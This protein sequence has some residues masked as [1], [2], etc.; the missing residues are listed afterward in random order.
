MARSL[1]V[2]RAVGLSVGR[3]RAARRGGRPE[4]ARS[5]RRRTSP[6]RLVLEA[7]TEPFVIL[8]I[9][10]GVL[11]IALGEMRDGL[12]VLLALIPIV[13]ADVVTDT[14]ANGRSRR[15]ARHR[16]RPRASGATARPSRPQRPGWCPGDIV[17][18]RAGD[19][20][21][22]DLRILR[23]DRLLIDRSVLTGESVPEPAVA[24]PDPPD[25]PLVARRVDGLRRH[26]RRRRARRGRRRRHRRRAPRSGGSRRGSGSSSAAGRR[27]RRE[28]D[29]LVRILLVVAH[30]ADR[31]RDRARVRSRP[32]GRG[33]PAGRHLGRDRGDPR[34][35]AG[36]ARGDPRPGRVP[37]AA[38]RRPRPAAQR[39]G[40]ARLG[41]PDHH[42]QDRDADPQPARRRVRDRLDRTGRRATPDVALLEA[43]LR[44][45]DDAWV[46]AEGTAPGSFTASLGR[47]IEAAG[48]DGAAR[49]GRPARVRAGRRRPA[50]VDHPQPTDAGRDVADATV[51]L[52]IGAP[53][54]ILALADPA[55]RRAPRLARAGRGERRDRRAAGRA[56]RPPRRRAVGWSGP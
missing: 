26:E 12:L 33:E 28:L 38:A 20:V 36:P 46:R 24:E 42:R 21:P 9:V 5:R 35:A 25:A 55:A 50:A 22:A 30:R 8:L 14:A 3:G 17:L 54:A 56:G 31:H 1:G 34:G 45:E 27:S 39:R 29:R 18:L 6:G 19:I 7:A 11:A 53:E 13:A 40:D 16:P 32:A 4:R 52:A 44:A 15:C 10:A 41:R 49:S 37:A 23:A 48:G 43:A 2:D 47:A 51:E